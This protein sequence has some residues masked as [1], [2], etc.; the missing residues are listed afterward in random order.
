[1]QCRP[2]LRSGFT[3]VELLVVI[4]IIAMLVTLLLPGVQSAREA[5]RRSQCS[6]N[7]RQIGLALMNF[8]GAHGRLPCSRFRNE[9]PSWFAIILP[10]VE[11][12]AEAAQWDI[13]Q[14]YYHRDNKLARETLVAV[15]RCPSRGS[16]DFTTES[17]TDGPSSTVGAVG[18]FVGNAGNNNSRISNEF[19]RPEANG[20]I[21]TA[22]KFDIRDDDSLGWDSD[23]TF[24]RITDGLSKTIFAGEKHIP[25]EH[26]RKQGSMY[27]GDHQPNCAR[28]LGSSA[29]LAN[30]VNDT[31]RCQVGTCDTFGS[32][33]E[34]VVHFVFGDGH[35]AAIPTSA[36]AVVLGNLAA[37]DD[38]QPVNF[39]F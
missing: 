38:G 27:N 33:H 8:E 9:H 19:W 7:L 21:I 14:T 2:R 10:F 20:T 37:R 5:A 36:D 13:D 25:L 35:V 29:P 15:F 18:D 6:N 17:I 3:L 34:G 28:V 16:I 4:A 26:S 11:G 24:K 1:M 31:T 23:I 39:D 32:W 12:S 22:D 30:T